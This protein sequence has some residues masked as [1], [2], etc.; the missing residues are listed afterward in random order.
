MSSIWH[1][2]AYHSI[3]IILV[4]NGFKINDYYIHYCKDVFVHYYAYDSNAT[5]TFSFHVQR[6]LCAGTFKFTYTYE[7]GVHFDIKSLQS[8]GLSSFI[9]SEDIISILV[10]QKFFRVYETLSWEEVKSTK[11]KT[12]LKKMKKNLN[13]KTH[14]P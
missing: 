6:I 9:V 13:V 1:S 14:D 10:D 5:S 12:F 3:Y 8:L 4:Y 2:I 7:N 11:S